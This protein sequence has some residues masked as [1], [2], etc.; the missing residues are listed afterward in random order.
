MKRLLT[1]V[2]LALLFGTAYAGAQLTS[3]G[4]NVVCIPPAVVQALS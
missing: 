2:L 1:L 4:G 3:N